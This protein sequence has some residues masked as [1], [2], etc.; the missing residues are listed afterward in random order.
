MK[1][2]TENEAVA[3]VKKR[4]KTRGEAARLAEL[5]GVSRFHISD[6]IHGRKKPT[7]R[8]TEAL[9]LKRVTMY[10]VQS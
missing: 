3:L 4:V 6:V 8:L 1:R 10:E 9:G 7:I 2:L 5:S